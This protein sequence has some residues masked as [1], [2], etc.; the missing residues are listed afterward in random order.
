[1]NSEGHQ[2]SI[3]KFTDLIKIMSNQKKK[4]K[5]VGDRVEVKIYLYKKNELYEVK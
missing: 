5:L 2:N 4:F 1:M 3:F